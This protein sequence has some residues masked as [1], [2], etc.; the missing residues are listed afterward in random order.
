MAAASHDTGCVIHD[1][2]PCDRPPPVYT[3]TAA[4]Y[5][6]KDVTTRDVSG[7]EDAPV[8]PPQYQ[9]VISREDVNPGDPR[10]DDVITL[11]PP[12]QWAV[13]TTPGN[14]KKTYLKCETNILVNNFLKVYKWLSVGYRDWCI[15]CFRI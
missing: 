1:G 15:T 10:R 4:D 14:L 9:T 11:P 13:S 6:D 3:P 12:Y 8:D 2:P 7:S 5:M